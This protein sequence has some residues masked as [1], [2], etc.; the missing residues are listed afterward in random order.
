MMFFS[1]C[2]KTK[3][4]HILASRTQ[5][6]SDTAA[7]VWQASLT[8]QRSTLV[9]SLDPNPSMVPS[10]WVSFPWANKTEISLRKNEHFLK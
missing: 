10:L 8:E 9:K 5:N 2:L 7:S 4:F 1:T 6:P 3:C